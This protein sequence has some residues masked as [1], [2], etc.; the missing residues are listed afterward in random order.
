MQQ[1]E[2]TLLVMF[3]SLQAVWNTA[4]LSLDADVAGLMMQSRRGRPNRRLRGLIV[5]VMRS[6]YQRAP[7]LSGEL[8][9]ASKERSLTFIATALANATPRPPLHSSTGHA[10]CYPSP[11]CCRQH[12]T[13]PQ[14]LCEVS[15]RCPE[16]CRRLGANFWP[17]K[18]TTALLPFRAGSAAFLSSSSSNNATT[19]KSPATIPGNPGTPPPMKQARREVPLPSQEGKKGAMQYALYVLP[20]GRRRKR[21]KFCGNSG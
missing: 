13:E 2:G 16:S 18:P 15:R 21:R 17:A 20:L 14:W 12:G 19:L 4:V 11:I 7:K 1:I 8:G 5:V 10:P 6:T 3:A 9:M